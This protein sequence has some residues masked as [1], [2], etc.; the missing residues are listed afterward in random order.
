VQAAV[1]A[2]SAGDTITICPGRYVENLTISQDVTLTGA[3][4]GD[5]PAQHTILDA[6][7]SGRVVTVTAGSHVA[8]ERLR[9]TGGAVDDGAGLHN[10][11]GA[12]LTMTDCTVAGNTA[13]NEGGGIRNNV[14]GTLIVTNSTVIGNS[15]VAGGG[16]FNEAGGTLTLDSSS[17]TGNQA[18]EAGGGILNLGAVG[19]V[20]GS[21]VG[22]N[23]HAGFNGGG[24]RNEGTVACSGGSTV[25][26]NTAGSPPVTSNCLGL[27]GT[28]CG[29]CPA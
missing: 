18:A 23:N 5:K 20:N 25:S 21:S 12:T 28:G 4:D 19:L 14:N 22:P 3:G 8:L 16:I 13:S 10:G 6:N 17:V 7:R 11:T 27:V 2:A 24:I 29:T 9:I 26:G 1:N 15:A